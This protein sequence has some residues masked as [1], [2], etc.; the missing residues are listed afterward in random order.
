MRGRRA[1][2][3]FPPDIAVVSQRDICVKGIALDRFH[4]VRV[5]LV[6]RPRHY[7]EITVL[8]VNRIEPA[9]FPDLHPGDVVADRRHFPSL[10]MRR[11]NQHREIGL[12]T[13]T[14]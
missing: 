14:G 10:E 3:A 13:R 12:S 7:T 8:R 1:V 11:W 5:R 4:R 9:V 2:L 6:T